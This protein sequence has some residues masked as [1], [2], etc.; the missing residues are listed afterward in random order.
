MTFGHGYI[1]I[2]ILKPHKISEYMYMILIS[3]SP[4]RTLEVYLYLLNV[5]LADYFNACMYSPVERSD[6]FFHYMERSDNFSPHFIQVY[7]P[8]ER[9]DNFSP[10]FKQV[11]SPIERSDNFFPLYMHNPLWKGQATLVY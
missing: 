4:S 2:A 11:Y 10:H 9:S 5:L 3:R 6:K 8:I 1:V 7:S